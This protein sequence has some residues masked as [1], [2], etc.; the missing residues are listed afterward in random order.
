MTYGSK[1]YTLLGTQREQENADW[2]SEEGVTEILNKPDLD[3]YRLVGSKR[4]NAD[5]AAGVGIGGTNDLPTEPAYIKNKPYF[6][7][8]E[9][10]FWNLV[11]LTPPNFVERTHANDIVG[12]DYTAAANDP[13]TPKP[14]YQ[15]ITQIRMTEKRYY[16]GEDNTAV[17]D[18]VLPA[19]YASDKYKP[20]ICVEN[21]GRAAWYAV[22]SYSRGANTIVEVNV[23]F[24]TENENL[25][26][27]G[28]IG[29]AG[30]NDIWQSNLNTGHFPTRVKLVWY[31]H[32]P[33]IT[34][35]GLVPYN[36]E[37]IPE[38][39]L[40]ESETPVPSDWNS[41]A[42]LSRILNKP[43]IPAAATF[44]NDTGASGLTFANLGTAW[45]DLLTDTASDL[46]IGNGKLAIAYDGQILIPSNSSADY[47]LWLE[48]TLSWGSPTQT[49]Y[50][51][52]DHN[53]FSFWGGDS[54]QRHYI[55]RGVFV[56]AKEALEGS[57]LAAPYTIKLR[58]LY[59]ITGG[60][61][62]NALQ[63]RDLHLNMAAI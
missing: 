5:W 47:R 18:P 2:N 10:G 42:G 29:Q 11:T 14:L 27:M 39:L 58:G 36:G 40:P 51:Y 9:W 21:Y 46:T 61:N 59:T 55:H 57:E 13:D 43:T 41:Q 22:T 63:Y 53:A 50:L 19:F 37:K 23:R 15:R 34:P 26:K 38:G 44:Y 3:E 20:I 35:S 17:Q 49:I 54:G 62:T 45:A 25:N 52:Q 6:S 12:L 30:L 60:A 4:Y 48:I 28:G 56:D 31:S 7:T 1:L 24:I 33:F 16:N 32:Q 8:K